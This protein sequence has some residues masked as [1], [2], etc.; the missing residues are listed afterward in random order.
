ML[1]HIK[2]H[3][4]HKM[5]FTTEKKLSNF[6][7]PAALSPLNPTLSRTQPKFSPPY[8]RVPKRCSLLWWIFNYF[9]IFF[10][11]DNLHTRTHKE[12]ILD[13]S[14]AYKQLRAVKNSCFNWIFNECCI[15]DY[16]RHF[17]LSY[18]FLSENRFCGEV[19]L[20]II[21]LCLPST[22][23]PPTN[24]H[25]TTIFHC[26]YPQRVI[27]RHWK[28]TTC[29]ISKRRIICYF[30]SLATHRLV[31]SSDFRTTLRLEP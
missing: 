20:F 10:E 27:K 19:G 26:N 17:E 3:K 7:P 14:R 2:R 4:T 29:I 24:F 5:R 11:R 6:S 23:S 15:L 1:F 25:V 9:I 22:A 31:I 18:N 21:F 28:I 30:L 13:E 16:E 12:S 8:F